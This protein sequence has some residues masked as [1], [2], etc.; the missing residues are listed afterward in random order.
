MRP[1]FLQQEITLASVTDICNL[2]LSHLGEEASVIAINPAD[3]TRQSTLC[4]I[5]YPIVRDVVLSSFGWTFA[6][7]R[8]VLAQVVNPSPDDW[9][10]AYALPNGCLRPL[11]SL[12]P[13]VP[14][15]NFGAGDT[16]TGTFP[17][18]IESSEDGKGVLYTNLQTTTLRYVAQVTDTTRF[19]PLVVVAMSRLLAAYLA[20]PIITG[21]EGIKVSQ[22]QLKW[23][24]LEMSKA[25]LADAS[26]GHRDLSQYRPDWI[27]AR[28]G[29]YGGN[30]WNIPPY[31]P[32]G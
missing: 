8:R 1:F 3:G 17:Y 25:M 15:A 13:G 18:L 10:Y 7:R 28:G 20:G 32:V 2:A 27:T 31:G 22:A 11:Q 16:D 9:G 6:T 30:H 14:A 24:D 29:G 12:N 4:G 23:F 21:T 5:Y 26:I 19:T